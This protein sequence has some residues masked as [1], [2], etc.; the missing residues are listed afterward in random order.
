MSYQLMNGLT[1]FLSALDTVKIFGPRITKSGDTRPATIFGK[2]K[3][4]VN[5]DFE[6]VCV[7][8]SKNQGWG[9]EKQIKEFW[10]PE[11]RDLK[12]LNWQF[13]NQKAAF[14]NPSRGLKYQIGFSNFQCMYFKNL[15][16]SFENHIIGFSSL[17][18]KRNHSGV[19]NHQKWLQASY[20]H[21]QC[22]KKPL[23][24]D[25]HALK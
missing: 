11:Y 18:D 20:P 4:R 24:C 17:N 6:D 15:H 2:W 1:A 10:N 12:L 25:K 13:Q 23:N 16:R 3:L 14:W 9:P 22:L 21:C 5:L 19:S 8:V 7:S